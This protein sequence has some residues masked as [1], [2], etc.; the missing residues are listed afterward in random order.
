MPITGLICASKYGWPLVFYIYG[1]IGIFWCILWIIFGSDNPS[2]H[3]S[4]SK[5]ER[6]WLEN[7]NLD[8]NDEKVRFIGI[9]F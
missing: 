7:E 4:I 9:I 3:K 1:G 8:R 2:K 6:M 5:A